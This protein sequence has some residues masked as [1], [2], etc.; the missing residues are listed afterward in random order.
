M[1]RRWLCESRPFLTE[2]WPFLCAMVASPSSS[3]GPAG[4]G[5]G[6]YEYEDYRGRPGGVKESGR[7][8]AAAI[9]A[10][11]SFVEWRGPPAVFPSGPFRR[12][13]MLAPMN[14]T[15]SR[16]RALGAAITPVA[17]AA[18]ACVL[19][20]ARVGE[21]RAEPKRKELGKNVYFETDGDRRRVIVNASVVLR[22]GQLEGLLTITRTKG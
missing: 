19:S 9:A 17:V 13:G 5:G 15:V 3:A 6:W 20:L 7:A 21:A 16:W 18:V 11:G 22:D 2:P 14:T 8:A 4:R 1:P 12:T 10:P